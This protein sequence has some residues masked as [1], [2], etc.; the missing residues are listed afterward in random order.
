[1]DRWGRPEPTYDRDLCTL[2][3]S[4]GTSRTTTFNRRDV[5]IESAR[6]LGLTGPQGRPRLTA[7][8][9]NV[10]RDA[11]RDGPLQRPVGSWAFITQVGEVTL[12]K[13]RAV[14]GLTRGTDRA[15]RA[16]CAVWPAGRSVGHERAVTSV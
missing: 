3:P 12:G 8:A 15:I 14:S 2:L 4:T 13:D 5:P 11:G 9:P 6:D 1:M 10:W 16:R 7:I